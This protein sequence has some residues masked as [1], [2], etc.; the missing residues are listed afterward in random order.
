MRGYTITQTQIDE[1]R[2]LQGQGLTQKRIAEKMGLNAVTI[3]RH[4]GKTRSTVSQKEV[5]DMQV[6]RELG[7]S[8]A[9]IAKEMGFSK[10]TVNK[11]IGLQPK[12]R[13]GAYGSLVAH[14]TGSSF[15]QTP[16]PKSVRLDAEPTKEE[17]ELKHLLD[18]VVTT[19]SS[20]RGL[21]LV[22]AIVTYDGRDFC[23]KIDKDGKIQMIHATGQNLSLDRETFRQFVAEINELVRYM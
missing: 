14:P 9:Q 4:L 16:V 22:S 17:L 18:H 10:S 12:G 23:Y 5:D 8:N 20:P 7:L 2:M 15:V 13:R 11:H 3:R 6:Y 19:E 1:M 21:K